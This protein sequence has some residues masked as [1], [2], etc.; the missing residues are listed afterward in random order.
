[1]NLTLLS[2]VHFIFSQVQVFS[3]NTHPFATVESTFCDINH[4]ICWSFNGETGVRSYHDYDG[5][6]H[7]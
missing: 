6:I 3:K 2:S 5:T 4:D 7:D 1:M